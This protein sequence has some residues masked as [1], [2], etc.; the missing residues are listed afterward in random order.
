M[1]QLE[2]DAGSLTSG[3]M[4]LHFAVLASDSSLTEVENTLPEHLYHCFFLVR[5][6]LDRCWVDNSVLV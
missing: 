1:D 2:D 4:V 3:K 5:Q 6:S